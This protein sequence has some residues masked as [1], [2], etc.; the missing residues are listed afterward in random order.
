MVFT[1]LPWNLLLA[2][3][4]FAPNAA[5]AIGLLFARFALSQMDVPMR[6]AYVTT[7]VDPDERV[8][9]RGVHVRSRCVIRP[10]GPVLARGSPR[11]SRSGLPAA[12]RRHHQIGLRPHLVVVAAPRPTW[13]MR[14]RR[15]C[16]MIVCWRTVRVWHS[17]H[18]SVRRLDGTPTA[19]VGREHGR[20]LRVRAPD[21]PTAEPSQDAEPETVTPVDDEEL[22]V[23]TVWPDHDTFDAWI[24]T[25]DR[26][27]ASPHPPSTRQS[28]SGQSRAL[29]VIGGYHANSSAQLESCTHPT[30]ETP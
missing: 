18:D 11:T 26:D 8:Q 16:P 15:G 27:P 12:D 23:V 17:Q 14:T 30:G 5:I 25:P 2:G 13:N 21:L 1:H 9:P 19:A 3:V 4:A 24:N 20:R 29:D 28:S 7:M 22:V 10:A 6:Q